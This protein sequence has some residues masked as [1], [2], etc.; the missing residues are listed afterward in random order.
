MEET[1]FV[2]A[3]CART[4]RYFGLEVKKIGSEWRVVNMDDLSAADARLL[5]TQVRQDVFQSHTTL[6]ACQKCGNRRVG[7]CACAQSAHPCSPTMAYRFD[8]LYCTECKIDYS[9]PSRS[10]VSGKVGSTIIV[11]GKEVKVV[12]FSNAEWKKFDKLVSHTNGRTNG[13]PSEPT[14][15]VAASETNIE[16]HGY[17]ISA[18]DEG[19]Y[20][21]IGEQDDFTIECDVDTS[22]IQPHPGGR[23]YISFGLITANVTQNGGSFLL[24]GREV[25]KVGSRFRMKLSLTEGGKYE[26]FVNGSLCG[27]QTQ[28]VSGMTRITFGFAHDSHNCDILSHAYLKDIKMEQGVA[29]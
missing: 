4:N 27:S 25:T 28:R 6:L 14:V 7:G 10:D 8:C 20:Y 22:T 13:Y 23:L 29:Q 16:F 19:V 1:K 18:M 12:T 21:D 3:H 15:H 5:A 2:K 17:N 24:N 11:Q 9:L 26:I